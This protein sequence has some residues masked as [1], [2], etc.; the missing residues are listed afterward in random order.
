MFAKVFCC[1]KK[2]KR[3]TTTKK[4]ENLIRIPTYSKT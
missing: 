2:I 3:N 4:T 1:G